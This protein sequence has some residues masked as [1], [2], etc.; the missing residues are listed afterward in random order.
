MRIS[1]YK[2]LQ[3]DEG[4]KK[5]WSNEERQR[6]LTSWVGED[7]GAFTLVDLENREK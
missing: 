7:I 4:E 6:E 1:E 3:W 5:D 2:D